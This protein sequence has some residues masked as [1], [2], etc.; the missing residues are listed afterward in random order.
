MLQTI[1][2]PNNSY[3][4]DEHTYRGGITLRYTKR[5]K[6][7]AT[8]AIPWGDTADF[9]NLLL[10]VTP[11]HERLHYERGMVDTVITHNTMLFEPSLEVKLF[12]KKDHFRPIQLRLFHDAKNVPLINFVDF[13][14]D[15]TP[16][17]VRLGNP[18][19]KKWTAVTWFTGEYKDMR[20]A[21]QNWYASTILSYHHNDVAQSV[22]FNP[23]T[24]VYTYRPEN[25]S[26]TWCIQAKSGLFC[27][28]D[29]DRRWTL[30]NKVHGS[31]LHWL[32]YSLLDG[33]T[34]SD[35]IAVNTTMLHDEAYI[36][37]NKEALNVRLTGDIMW[38]HSEGR[39]RDLATLNAVDFQY[40]VNARH[41]LPVQ[42]TTVSADINMYS[43][44]GYGSSELNADD[45][46]L[47]ASLSQPLLKGKLIARLEVFDLLHQLSTP[48]MR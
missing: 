42:K 12:M 20:S 21:R 10:S 26:G 27:N 31:Y 1:T 15:A 23:E 6:M 41:T 29:A 30:E 22:I 7:K 35:V 25:V 33:A 17:I 19:L 18:D 3:F 4:S 9:L 40:G 24:G 2:D 37:Y 32:G 44:C 38:R 8:E 45:L 39:I 46:V 34:E 11:T 47:N 13:R 14:D 5:Q 48:N 16:L 28:L 36:Q 43:R